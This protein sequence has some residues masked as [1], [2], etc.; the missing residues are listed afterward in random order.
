[1]E[2]LENCEFIIDIETIDRIMSGNQG[3]ETSCMKY[4]LPQQTK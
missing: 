1:M 4:T 2:K 3:Q